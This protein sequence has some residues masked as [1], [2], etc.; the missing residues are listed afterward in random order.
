MPGLLNSTHMNGYMQADILGRKRGLKFGTIAI[1]QITLYS[2]KN[3]KALGETLDLALIPIIVY[4]GLFNNCYIKQED[5]DFTFE[6][7]VEF[8]DDNI[9][10]PEIFT[11]IVKCLY[12]SKLVSVAVTTID[13]KEQKK[14]STLPKRKGGTS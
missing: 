5:P 8:V 11:D 1:R 10:K 9:S 13:E 7:V 14:S 4:W 12:S 3:G 6:D 2:E